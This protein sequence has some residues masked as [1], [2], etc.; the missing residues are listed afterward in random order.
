M[1]TGLWW[2]LLGIVLVGVSG[3][4]VR[5]SLTSKAP[6]P[7]VLGRLH[8]F[9]LRDQANKP[10]SLKDLQGKTWVADFIYTRCPDQCPMLS[11][12]MAAFQDLIPKKA[13]VHLV[14]ITVD[15]EHDTPATLADY[16]A[17]YHADPA[18]W[19]FL[20]GRPRDV[21]NL[22]IDFKLLPPGE[23]PEIRRLNHSTP[24]VLVDPK[25][26]IR[27]YYDAGIE[28]EVQQLVKDVS[29]IAG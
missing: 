13:Q 21:E 18:R 28:S 29:R 26:Q 4:Y 27:G 14:S 3:N 7:P 10:L 19:L 24:L 16:A 15:P 9:T 12:K 22:V 23:K 25:G 1:K 17:R 11:R 2:G 8:P 6:Q 5:Q 20:T